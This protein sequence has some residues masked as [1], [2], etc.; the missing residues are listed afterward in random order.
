MMIK[1]GNY[2]FLSNRLAGMVKALESGL[3]IEE[4]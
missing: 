3:T 2:W 1:K 4:N